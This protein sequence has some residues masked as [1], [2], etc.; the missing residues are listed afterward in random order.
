MKRPQAAI[1][2][3]ARSRARLLDAALHII[4]SKGYS[5]TTVD[6]I[7]TAA[8]LSKGSFFHY[9]TSKEDLAV[10][11]AEHFATMA[12]GLFASAPYHAAADPLERLLGYVEFRSSILRGELPEF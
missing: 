1:H 9:F 12:A 4:R 7:C 2:A 11:A 3:Q 6:D 10:A 8:G 5:A